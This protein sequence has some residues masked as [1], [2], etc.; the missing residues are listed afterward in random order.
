MPSPLEKEQQIKTLHRKTLQRFRHTSF[1]GLLML[2][3]TKYCKVSYFSVIKQL[4]QGKTRFF[5]VIEKEGKQNINRGNKTA[6]SY[7]CC[8]F[9]AADVK[10]V[11][12]CLSVSAHEKYNR[13][14]S[15]NIMNEWVIA[16]VIGIHT[17]YASIC[18][19]VL[20]YFNGFRIC[21]QPAINKWVGYWLGRLI[22]VIK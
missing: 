17:L 13:K 18:C 11:W 19:L 21:K 14:P 8:F 10:T 9:N 20:W 5:S 4:R 22:C 15:Y 12:D 6:S 16:R 7:C 3:N 1:Y 2:N